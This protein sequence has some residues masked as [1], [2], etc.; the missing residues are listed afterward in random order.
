MKRKAD[1]I[2]SGITKEEPVQK[3]NKHEVNLRLDEIKKIKR[4][5]RSPAMQTEYYNLMKKQS[6]EMANPKEKKVENE[7]KRKR[8]AEVRKDDE[9]R[10]LENEKEKER[11]AEVRKDDETENWKMKQ[12]EKERLN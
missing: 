12:R 4:K 3:T 6:R 7:K 10:K 2:L 5:D 1:Q 8:Q 9:N 11:K